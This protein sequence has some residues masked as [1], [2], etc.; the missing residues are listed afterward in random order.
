M[1]RE[2]LNCW[3]TR[4]T[5]PQMHRV[6]PSYRACPACGESH[7]CRR[8]GPRW[9]KPSSSSTPRLRG[10]WWEE[11]RTRDSGIK[12]AVIDS[13]IDQTHP[14]FQ[15]PLLT[16]PPGFP[17]CLPEDCSFTNNKVIVARSYIRQQ[18]AGTAPDP[19]ADSRPDDY[20]PRDHFGHGTAVAMV[21]AG[22]TNT[23]PGDTITGL[24][25]RAFLGSYKIFGSPGVNDSASEDA[26][27]QALE[28]AVTDGMDIAN[29]SLGGPALNGALDSGAACGADPGVACDTL[30]QAVEAATS[31]GMLVVAAAG[32]EGATGVVYPTLGSVSTPAIAPSSIAVAA[33]TNS[34]TWISLPTGFTPVDQSTYNTVAF[35][36]SRGPAIGTAAIKPEIAAVGT[37]LFMAAQNYDPNGDL[38]SALRY[39]DASGTSFSTPMVAG[40]AALVKQLH[41]GWQPWQIKSA[42][43]NTATQDVT[44][45][46]P[47]ANVPAVGAGK[48][49][50]GNAVSPS[51]T[52]NPAIAS[53]GVLQS[54]P[55]TQKFQVQNNGLGAANL[56]VS[57]QSRNPA[58]GVVVSIDQSTL[59][60]PPGENATFQVSLTGSVPAPGS[61]EGFIVLQGDAVTLQI[62][63]LYLVS[64]GVPKNIIPLLGTGDYGEAGQLIPDGMLAF[65]VIDPYG[66]PVPNVP[67]SFAVTRGGGQIVSPDPATNQEGIATAQAIAGTSGTLDIFSG[68]AA[69][70]T[71]QFQTREFRSR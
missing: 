42:L 6:W 37:Y 1:S 7:F 9:I 59:S 41:P 10:A 44:D 18:A 71:A 66:L 20:S 56:Q 24:A 30:S 3:S 4:S 46:G 51:V 34:H 47:T 45:N 68:T 57:I 15:D 35:F 29:L 64:D 62:P 16:P 27:I 26:V 52:V 38:Y 48:L 22:E 39:T 17:K 53:F 36:S 32:N 55:A 23:G 28:D 67:V 69:G 19:A 58:A 25:P 54:L 65:E 14:A 49:N 63:Y 21:A 33:T 70:L 43:V 2:L 13:G 31:L 60:I 11:S 12:I 61:Y 50:V 5:L 8:S 40:A